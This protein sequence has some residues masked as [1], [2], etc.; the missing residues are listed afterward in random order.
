MDLLLCR[1]SRREPELHS[2]LIVFGLLGT[3]LDPASDG[4]SSGQ[5]YP[6]FLILAYSELLG[7]PNLLAA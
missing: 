7:I 4:E 1:A 2:A 5:R 3:V 6:S